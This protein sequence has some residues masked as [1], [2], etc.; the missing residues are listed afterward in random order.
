MTEQI[1]EK[2][3]AILNQ[4]T[5]I[6]AEKLG[7]E[8]DEV[9]KEAS[10]VSD[11]GADSLDRVELFME[12]YKKFGVIIP[13]A[14]QEELQTVGDVVRLIEQMSDDPKYIKPNEVVKPNTNEKKPYPPKKP[15][16]KKNTEKSA[17]PEII[18][19]GNIMKMTVEQA[20]K[21]SEFQVNLTQ[22]LKKTGGRSALKL[23]LGEVLHR[24][25]QKQQEPQK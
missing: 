13:D 23:P 24:Y 4:I 22:V 11:L 18:F 14:Q 7:I 1:S 19:S 9:T 25:L 15:T 10:F 17:A 6:I 21:Q 20:L 8:P 12:F 3:Q 16:P 2:Q 5:P